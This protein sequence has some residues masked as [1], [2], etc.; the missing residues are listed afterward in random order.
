MARPSTADRQ[1]HLL[2]WRPCTGVLRRPDASGGK[3]ATPPAPRRG[4]AEKLRC[5][6]PRS[7]RIPRR[8]L[9]A[10]R[11]VA[12]A[13]TRGR[14][15]FQIPSQGK[16]EAVRSV[17]RGQDQS[18]G[19]AVEPLG[20]RPRRSISS[21]SPRCLLRPRRTC[22]PAVAS[23]LPCSAMF[24]GVHSVA[25]SRSKPA[26]GKLVAS[27]CKVWGAA[28]TN[29]RSDSA[30]TVTSVPHRR[31]RPTGVCGTTAATLTSEGGDPA[32]TGG[33]WC[34]GKTRDRAGKR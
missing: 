29:Q 30:V 9:R 1:V 23:P 4:A 31:P 26:P 8:V 22:S 14:T 24:A 18:R 7:R 10:L 27:S 21:A 33:I 5:L 16:L 20:R 12:L 2:P 17:S 13:T 6:V 25:R 3:E 11:R 34:L 15:V 28:P 32:V 19:D